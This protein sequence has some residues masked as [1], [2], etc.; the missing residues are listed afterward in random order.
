V[1]LARSSARNSVAFSATRPGFGAFGA[2]VGVGLA[3]FAGGAGALLRFAV[4]LG[5]IPLIKFYGVGFFFL[6]L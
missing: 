1:I 2:G 6:L 3:A 5:G 4:D